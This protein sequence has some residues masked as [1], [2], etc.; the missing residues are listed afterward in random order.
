M[1]I[2]M[3]PLYIP[4]SYSLYIPRTQY[5]LDIVFTGPTPVD[6]LPSSMY[7]LYWVLNITN[8]MREITFACL[9]HINNTVI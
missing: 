3:G 4:C 1:A 9:C 2:E 7:I 5:V 8:N 6:A